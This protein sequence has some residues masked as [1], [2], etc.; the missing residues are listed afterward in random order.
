MKNKGSKVEKKNNLRNLNS[1][2]R[3]TI[4]Y[5]NKDEYLFSL[6]PNIQALKEK[7]DKK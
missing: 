1:N 7:K 5:I 6:V 3:S 4:N 2:L